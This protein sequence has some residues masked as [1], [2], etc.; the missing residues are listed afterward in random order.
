MTQSTTVESWDIENF[1]IVKNF[2]YKNIKQNESIPKDY[3][4]AASAIVMKRMALAGYR[5]AD[6][7]VLIY[8]SYKTSM[9][10]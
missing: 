10:A 8:S 4:E 3:F 2:A 7:L 5:L 6:T 9:Q 1:E